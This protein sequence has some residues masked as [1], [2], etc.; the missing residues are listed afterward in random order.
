M[1][2]PKRQVILDL[3]YTRQ[4]DSR[5]DTQYVNGIGAAL[6]STFEHAGKAAMSDEGVNARTTWTTSED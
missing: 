6:V 1:R 5:S 2:L 3:Y 4:N